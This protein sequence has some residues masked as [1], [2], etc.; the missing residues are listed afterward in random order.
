MCSR[1]HCSFTDRPDLLS[2]I[3]DLLDKKYSAKKIE[4]LTGI[5]HSIVGRHH[6]H[7]HVKSVAEKIKKQKVNP[8]ARLLVQ[9]PDGIICDGSAIVP[10]NQITEDD[11]LFIVSYDEKSN[12]QNPAGL[13]LDGAW[14]AEAQIRFETRC[15]PEVHHS[16]IEDMHALALFENSARDKSLA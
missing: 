13:T 16:F 9:S 10:S 3:D 5:G 4:G 8:R 7:C 12:F 15:S 6:M 11:V 14:T 1:N 2:V